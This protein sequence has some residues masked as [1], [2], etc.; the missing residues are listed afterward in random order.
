MNTSVL[1]HLAERF[2]VPHP[3]T[4]VTEAL[5]FVLNRHPAAREV[6][7][8]LLATQA[9]PHEARDWIK[10]T[11][12]VSGA[13][14]SGRV[15]VAGQADGSTWMSIEGKF[16]APLTCNQP[17]EYVKALEEGGSTLFVCPAP[18][19]PRLRNELAARTVEAGQSAPNE[20]WRADPVGVEWLA[21]TGDRRMGITSWP[22]L[23]AVLG[24]ARTDRQMDSD[25]YQLEGIVKKF[26]E[27]LLGWTPEEMTSG[28]L[29]STFTK[30]LHTTRV[31]CRIV[32]EELGAA[33]APH[34]H[35]PGKSAVLP[36][37]ELWDW[38][39]QR[40]G[41]AWAGL[42]VCLEPTTYWGLEGCR[43]PLRLGFNLAEARLPLDH[44]YQVYLN[45]HGLS[46]QL[47]HDLSGL[48]TTA[49]APWSDGW[50]LLPFPLR[51]GLAGE[52]A[53]AAMR[54]T[55]RT[56]VAPLLRAVGSAPLAGTAAI[57][58][59]SAPGAIPGG[60]VPAPRT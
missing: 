43:S 31:L 52:E 18:R 30:A 47:F 42:S 22:R 56:L 15:D 21:L 24:D 14:S 58:A 38:Y 37:T 6:M 3:E 13:E 5:C 53:A 34:W 36:S 59:P 2:K 4:L 57:T 1:A 45:M 28:G 17:V 11:S 50:W 44:L 49:P 51:P 19:I 16:G 41:P 39:G 27:E 32:A 9:M 29:G 40:F 12:E 46:D 20:P 60:P 33:N 25:L 7:I 35:A 48:P 23:I 54:A 8:A 10:F 55:A 26:E